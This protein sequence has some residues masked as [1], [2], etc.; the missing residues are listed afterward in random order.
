M[1]IQ[2][3]DRSP[4][5]RPQGSDLYS[6]GAS[7]APPVRPVA[8]PHPIESA[9]RMGEGAVVK[10]P[11][12]PSDTDTSNRDWTQTK[13]Q[14]TVKEPEEPPKEPISKMLIEFIQ[15]MWRASAAAV[16][17]AEAINKSASQQE[18][19]NQVKNETL[20]YTEPKV[21]RTSGL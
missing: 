8:A 10:E 1:Q 5:W 4:N 20:T 7:G 11:D 18:K 12:K 21:K 16:D 15:S 6:T 9:D 3:V 19:A 17:A 13:K 14:E 2:P